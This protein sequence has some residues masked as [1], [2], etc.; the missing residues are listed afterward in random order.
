MSGAAS[1]LAGSRAIG[2]PSSPGWWIAFAFA[3]S[4]A[5]LAL[6]P[7]ALAA[8]VVLWMLALPRLLGAERETFVVERWG[9]LFVFLVA[10]QA[11][12]LDGV[13]G[14]RAL[15]FCVVALLGAGWLWRRMSDVGALLREPAVVLFGLFLALQVWSGWM[16]GAPELGDI[17]LDRLYVLETLL[18]TAV[19]A[20][21]PGGRAL[22]P[23]LIA[24]AA[25]MALPVMARELIDHER[26]GLVITEG[27]E[28]RAARSTVSRTWPGSRSTSASPSP[29]CCL[30]TARSAVARL[31]SF[32]SARSLGSSPPLRAAR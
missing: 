28:L 9:G 16:A 22:V 25:L 2:K 29:R 3:A 4:Y 23:A 8:V 6:G 15:L 17:A 18:V 14:L 24:L 10:A 11:E 31:R 32:R 30:P 7:V 19:L 1:A 20:R 12:R 26:L 27:G 21:R 5:L 13:L